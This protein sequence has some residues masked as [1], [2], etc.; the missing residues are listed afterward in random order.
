MGLNVHLRIIGEPSNADH[1]LLQALNIDH[2][3]ASRLSDEEMQA[4]YANADV[5]FRQ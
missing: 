2:S 5:L 1:S 4:E 3:W